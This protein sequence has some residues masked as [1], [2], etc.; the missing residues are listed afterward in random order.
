MPRRP[1][2]VIPDMPSSVAKH[3][4]H[5]SREEMDSNLSGIR[6]TDVQALGSPTNPMDTSPS[7]TSDHTPTVTAST[8]IPKSFPKKTKT[9]YVTHPHLLHLHLQLGINRP[10]VLHHLEEETLQLWREEK[11]ARR[12]RKE[13]EELQATINRERRRWRGSDERFRELWAGVGLILSEENIIIET[14]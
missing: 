10:A 7:S 9:T 4:Q 11:R 5:N 13:R 6:P 8:T 2:T 14:R 3:M 12:E 1:F